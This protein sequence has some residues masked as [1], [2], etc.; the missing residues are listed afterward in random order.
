MLTSLPV[1]QLKQSFTFMVTLD[2]SVFPGV[3]ECL[4]PG[5]ANLWQEMQLVPNLRP[6]YEFFSHLGSVNAHISNS[7]IKSEW[8]YLHTRSER[9]TLHQTASL[10]VTGSTSSKQAILV[11]TETL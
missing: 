4:V 8:P 3:I 1:D 7:N 9:S 2:L 5:Q 6:Q 10:V 11:L